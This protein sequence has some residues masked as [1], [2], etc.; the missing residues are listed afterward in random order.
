M[1][2]I[3]V[4]AES[5]I[6]NLRPWIAIS[7]PRARANLRVWSCARRLLVSMGQSRGLSTGMQGTLGINIP[8]MSKMRRSMLDEN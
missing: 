7:M 8:E 4:R 5:E 1:Q 2:R 6:A 3:C